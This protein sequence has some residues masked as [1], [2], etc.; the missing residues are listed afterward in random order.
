MSDISNSGKPWGGRF[1]ASTD[2]FVEQFTASVR[3]DQ[4]LAAHDIKGSV[5]HAKML[6]EVGIIDHDDCTKI[7]IGLEAIQAEIDGGK[8]EWSVALEL[9]SASAGLDAHF[10]RCLARYRQRLGCA[11]GTQ[12]RAKLGC[13]IQ[14]GKIRIDD[15]RLGLIEGRKSAASFTTIA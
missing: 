9:S 13:E 12:H 14:V 7:V 5:A 11:R 2:A 8:F 3:F 1:N 15:D 10:R 6:A 4:R